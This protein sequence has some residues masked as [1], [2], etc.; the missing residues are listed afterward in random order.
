[1]PGA[2]G[3]RLSLWQPCMHLWPAMSAACSEMLT[4][5][6]DIGKVSRQ[7][8]IWRCPS[9]SELWGQYLKC[10]AAAADSERGDAGCG[11]AGGG[12]LERDTAA[13][14]LPP[15]QRRRPGVHPLLHAIRTPALGVS[16]CADAQSCGRGRAWSGRVYLIQACVFAPWGN[17]G[18]LAACRQGALLLCKRNRE[19]LSTPLSA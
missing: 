4:E 9:L 18:A 19:V 16:A 15:R 7:I 5:C 11:R 12:G 3:A 13:V 6:A 17:P 1:M 8:V 14:G 2:E 10:S